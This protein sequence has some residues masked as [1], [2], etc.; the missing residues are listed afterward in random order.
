MKNNKAVTIVH[1]S[2]MK[3]FST[4]NLNRGNNYNCANYGKS[5]EGKTVDIIDLI[6]LM[7]EID[8][9]NKKI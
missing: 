1:L 6:K 2:E 9:E 7:S 4:H 8:V 3:P 5:G